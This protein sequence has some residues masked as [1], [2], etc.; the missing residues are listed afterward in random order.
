MEIISSGR[1]YA[2]AGCSQDSSLAQEIV[3]AGGE[4]PGTSPGELLEVL[5]SKIQL[6]CRTRGK[7]YMTMLYLKMAL[8][9]LEKGE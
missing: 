6:E 7:H 2:V 9:S 8:E 4:N 5:V 1:K 3:F